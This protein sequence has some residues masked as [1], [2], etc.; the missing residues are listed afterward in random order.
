M[1]KPQGK[2][3][4][5]GEQIKISNKSL[6]KIKMCQRPKTGNGTCQRG[7]H[8]WYAHTDAELRNPEQSVEDYMESQGITNYI[9]TD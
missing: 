9:I 1:N 2:Y 7:L 4:A 8:C 5:S 6:Y 3:P